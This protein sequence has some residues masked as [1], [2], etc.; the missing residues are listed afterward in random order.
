VEDGGV[1]EGVGG[2]VGYWQRLKVFNV[3]LCRTSLT[4]KRSIKRSPFGMTL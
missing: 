3:L 2:E 4:D 1:K